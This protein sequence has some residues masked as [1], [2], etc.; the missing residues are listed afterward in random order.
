MSRASRIAFLAVALVT[1][2]AVAKET[3]TPSGTLDFDLV[4][5]G[6]G[7]VVLRDAA[8][9]ITFP[10][11]PTVEGQTQPAPSGPKL[12][13]A[14]AQ[15]VTEREGYWFFVLPVPPAVTYDATVGETGA[16][17][18]AL[19]NVKGTIT[20]EK[21]ETFGGLSMRHVVATATV[22]GTL[23]QIQMYI[24]WDVKHRT[25][26]AFWTM[27]QGAPSAQASAFV[28][29]FKMNPAGAGPPPGDGK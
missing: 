28:K 11:K 22:E 15:V 25:L 21:R 26:V 8:W 9:E 17:D 13:T 3:A 14:T 16:R 1:S 4:D 10:S 2:V 20:S 7:A 24:G 12:K 23:L 5:R 18:Q 29:S 6:A 27:S 19:A